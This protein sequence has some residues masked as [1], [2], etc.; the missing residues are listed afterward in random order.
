VF[1]LPID[2]YPIFSNSIL[3]SIFSLALFFLWIFVKTV[4]DVAFKKRILVSKLKV[5]DVLFESKVWEGISEKELKKIKASGKKFV[6]IKEGVRF[7]PVFPLALILTL[8]YG[9]A[10]TFLFFSSSLHFPLFS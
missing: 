9:N 2:F 8:L 6:W 10:L 3:L 5:G 1:R 7:A 4:E